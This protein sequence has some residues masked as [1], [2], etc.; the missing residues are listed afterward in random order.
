MAENRT[1][2]GPSSPRRGAAAGKAAP[3]GEPPKAAFPFRCAAVDVGSNAI[4]LMAVEFTAP[5]GFAPLFQERIPIR[6]GHEVFLTGK[7]SREAMDGAV[8]ALKAFSRTV[9]GL[10][11]T[12]VRA[13][14]TSAVREASNGAEFTERIRKEAKFDLEVISGYEEARLIHLAVRHRIPM[15]SQEW[16]LADLGGGS[17][18]VSLADGSGILWSESHTM[19]AVRLLEEIS[20]GRE[21]PGRF[22][23]LLEEYTS[24]LRVPASATSGRR[25]GFIATGGNVEAL[26]Q[27]AGVRPGPHGVSVL[28]LDSLRQLIEKLA[29]LSYRQRVT[30]LG[31]KEDRADVI[32]PAAIVYERLGLLVGASA[33]HVPHVG[34][35]EGLLLDLAESLTARQVHEDA[36]DRQVLAGAVALGR[37]YFFDEAHGRHVA[38]LAASLFD[39]LSELHGMGP[40]EKRLLCAA[41]VLHDLGSY[42]SF[43]GHHKHSAYV[44]A[45]SELPGFSPQEM[46]QTAAV[47]RYHRKGSPKLRH[48][49]Y[50]LL[51]RGERRTVEALAALLRL[52]DALDREHRQTVRSAWVR[53]RDGAAELTLEGEGEMLLE[54]WALK[55]KA[56]LF[57]RVY[58]V[59]VHVTPGGGRK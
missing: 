56:D 58:G 29:G 8:Q 24:T 45:N 54:R 28:P 38:E 41:A 31:L 21:E 3:A 35:K 18:E 13:V 40:Q 42:I 53:V 7:L 43:K 6:L 9:E 22:L 1:K 49:E 52:A 26:A 44:V 14:T 59:E 32:L 15:G 51:D 47:A 36:Q 20:G 34:L 17:V 10:K 19:G 25:L 37:R 5:G 4:R 46:L 16:L 11:A 27:L 50:A 23:D 30:T 48:D 12:H 33:I 55:R 57:G 39:Q 2:K